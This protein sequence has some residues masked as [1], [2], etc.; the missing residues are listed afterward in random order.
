MQQ[1]VFTR[2]DLKLANE[3]LKACKVKITIK[4]EVIAQFSHTYISTSRNSISSQKNCRDDK[5]NVKLDPGF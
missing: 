3:F 4:T 1:V 5:L 2:P